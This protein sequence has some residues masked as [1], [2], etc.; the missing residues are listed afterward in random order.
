MRETKSTCPYCGVG[1][2]VIIQS[3]DDQITGVRGDPA[4]SG[5]LRSSVQQRQ[6]V[7]PH[8]VQARH[9]ANAAAAADAA[10]PARRRAAADR[11]G[12]RTRSRGRAHRTHGADPRPR[13]RGPVPVGSTA[14]RGLLR[15][16]QAGTRTDRHQQR[17]HQLAPVH[18]LGGGR[19]QA[20]ARRRCAAVLL[21]RPRPCAHAVHH[22]QQ[23]GMGAPDPDA[24]AR[25]RARRA[26]RDEVDRGRSTSHRDRG[27]GR[28]APADPARHRHHAVPRHRASAVVGGS[29]RSGLHRGAHARVR[30]LARPRARPHTARGG[31]GLW[32][33]GERPGAGGTLV[34]W[35]RCPGARRALADAVAVLPGFEP[36]RQRHAQQRGADQPA[37]AHRADRQARRWPV[38]A[39]R[40]AQRDG[41]SRGRCPGQPARRAPRPRQCRSPRRNGGA[42]GR[43]GAALAGGQVGRRDVRGRGRRCHQAAVDRLHESGAVHAA[44]V[45]GAARVRTLRVRD[46]AGGVSHHGNLRIRRSLAARQHLG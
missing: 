8:R 40:P 7:A 43:T 46:R 32:H 18:E 11:V 24:P 27:D 25:G 22:R 28:P 31:P 38:F 42:V 33:R 4:A 34:R 30:G 41:W 14:D 35:R 45:D 37:P 15:F 13:R 12:R 9:D 19:L 26:T 3:D 1:C 23:H 2:G 44:P 6:H 10:L 20:H 16:Q 5:Q 17:R 29:D 21:R 36:E 39:H